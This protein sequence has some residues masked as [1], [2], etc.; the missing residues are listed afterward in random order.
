MDSTD[1]QHPFDPLKNAI[2]ITFVC[3]VSDIPPEDY[4]EATFLAEDCVAN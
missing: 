3:E 2:D 4:V 1:D